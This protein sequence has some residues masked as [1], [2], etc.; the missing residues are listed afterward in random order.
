LA[1]CNATVQRDASACHAAATTEQYMLE[2]VVL[3]N[4]VPTTNHIH[5]ISTHLTDI[6]P[7]RGHIITHYM[8]VTRS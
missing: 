7:H 8:I 5:V 4:T 3:N 2:Q 1:V 6:Q